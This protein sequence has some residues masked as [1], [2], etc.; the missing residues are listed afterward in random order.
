MEMKNAAKCKTR[1]LHGAMIPVVPV[2]EF[3]QGE[4]GPPAGARHPPGL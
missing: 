1:Q 2:H 3:F 4:R